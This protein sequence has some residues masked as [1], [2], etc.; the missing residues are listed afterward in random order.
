MNCPDSLPGPCQLELQWR[1]G[2]TDVIGQHCLQTQPQAPWERLV[3]CEK[4]E[5]AAR[6]KVKESGQL[7][8]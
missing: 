3:I 1:L 2:L 4:A 6:V 5:V 8:E 7:L